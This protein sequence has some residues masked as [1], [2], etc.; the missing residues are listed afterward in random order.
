MSCLRNRTTSKALLGQSLL[1]SLGA[2]V[3]MVGVTGCGGAPPPVG[4]AAPAPPVEAPQTDS[5]DLDEEPI[6]DEEDDANRIAPN[7]G[8]ISE[9]AK[10]IVADK[11]RTDEDRKA[12]QRRHP[13][14]LLTFVGL[15]PGM[16]VADSGRRRWLHHRTLGTRGRAGRERSSRRTTSTR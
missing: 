6:E 7:P 11:D 1:S 2:A 13:A 4:P 16:K 15:K 14:E 3:L 8:P 10:K 12:D 9:E 5:S